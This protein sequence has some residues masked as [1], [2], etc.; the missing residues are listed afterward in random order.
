MSQTAQNAGADPQS[1]CIGVCRLD[2]SNTCIGC[3]RL[4]SE[5]AAWSRMTSE[6][7]R[8]VCELAA[9]RLRIPNRS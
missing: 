6:E 5:V 3:G 8:Q 1:P 7:R 2:P 4:L 9:Q